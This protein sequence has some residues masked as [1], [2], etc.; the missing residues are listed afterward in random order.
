MVS[1]HAIGEINFFCHTRSEIHILLPPGQRFMFFCRQDRD[2]CFSVKDSCF[3][4]MSGQRFMF[5]LPCQVKDSCFSAMSG[6][7]FMFFCHARS[8]IHVF[9]PC[10][11]KDS[12]FPAMPG[13]GFMFFCHVRS[14]IHVFL[15]CQVKDSCF[16]ATIRHFSMFRICDVSMDSSEGVYG[17]CVTGK[18]DY[19]THCQ[20]SSRFILTVKQYLV[21][22]EKA[23]LS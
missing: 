12:C 23:I 19:D 16:H 6:Q 8:R 2:S 9:L 1:F 11:V 20:A 3:S 21:Y 17:I 5:Y 22:N 18:S 10:Q 13:Q 7:R 14:K 15:P 4:A